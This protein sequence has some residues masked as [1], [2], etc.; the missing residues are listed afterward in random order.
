[1]ENKQNEPIKYES[2]DFSPEKAQ[3]IENIWGLFR[4]STTAPTGKPVKFGDQI[5]VYTNGSTYRLY[6]YDTKNNVWH[7]ITASA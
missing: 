4:T 5:V 7:Y 2:Q 3:R 1:M 6:W